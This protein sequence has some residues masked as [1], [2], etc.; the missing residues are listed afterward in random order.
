MSLHTTSSGITSGYTSYTL[1]TDLIIFGASLGF[2]ALTAFLE[3]S[4][5]T[6][7]LFKLKELAQKT[8]RYRSLFQSLEKNHSR[9]LTTILIAKNLADV[10]AAT[11]GAELT[12]R[13][14]SFLPEGVGTWL[15][16]GIV[17]VLILVFG[18]I[19]P[20]IIAKAYGERFFS[21]TLGITNTLYY[22]LY[23]LVNSF[24]PFANF[25]VSKLTGNRVVESTD[26][27][28]SEKEIRFLIDYIT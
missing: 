11:F 16:I 21:S 26:H 2:C 18:E 13:L 6:L 7:R 5:T 27:V 3:T 17:T 8:E 28:T 24:L 12:S 9:V 15:G 14:L 23:P 19:I 25:I 1:S 4:I 10:T 22:L 20:K